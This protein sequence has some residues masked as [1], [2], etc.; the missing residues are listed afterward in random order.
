MSNTF[1]AHGLG[2]ILS[3]FQSEVLTLMNEGHFPKPT[4]SPKGRFYWSEATIPEWLVL[5]GKYKARIK[6]NPLVGRVVW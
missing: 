1:D 2:D 4:I 3:L 6:Q 5:V